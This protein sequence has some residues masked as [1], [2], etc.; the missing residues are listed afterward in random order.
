MKNLTNT[1]ATLPEGCHL[2]DTHCHLDM[3]AF[4]CDLEMVLVRAKK[5][6]IEF[7]VTIGIDLP[8]S[9]TAVHL[10]EQHSFIRASVG[11][12]PHDVHS[13]T[14]AMYLSLS[15]LIDTNRELVVGYGEIGLDYVKKHT[16]PELQRKHFKRQLEIA[17]EFE[18]P[19][20]VHDREAHD[21]I[22]RILQDCGPY[23]GG[24]VMH[25]FSGDYA[26]AQRILDL[27]FHISIPGI[28]TFKNATGLQEVARMVP[29]SALLVETD[30]PFLAPHPWRGQRNEPSFLLQTATFIAGLRNISL[31]ELAD[32]TSANA[33]SLFGLQSST[34]HIQ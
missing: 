18:L 14:D 5:C 21:D 2:I 12:H 9:Q 23:P 7:I 28:V 34:I 17:K 13:A 11:I 15:Q 32:V 22:L 29:L 4:S 1:P 3:D 26:F 20:I 6:G 27:G 31:G 8:S 19:V 16:D 24:G 25:C 30:G 33:I 10:A